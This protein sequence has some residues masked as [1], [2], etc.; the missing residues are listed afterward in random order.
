MPWLIA[1]F[2]LKTH[3]R[4]L[5]FLLA[6]IPHNRTIA[7]NRQHIQWL[8]GFYLH[9]GCHRID[10]RDQLLGDVVACAADRPAQEKS[11]QES[12][13]LQTIT[14]HRRESITCDEHAWLAGHV[15][16]VP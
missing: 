12:E 6:R 8:M 3:W 9:A 2:N 13:P 5:L 1:L 15:G 7:P 4:V 16:V 10:A 11:D 14:P